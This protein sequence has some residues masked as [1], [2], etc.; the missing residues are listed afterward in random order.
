MWPVP[1]AKVLVDVFLP[2]TEKMGNTGKS[3]AFLTSL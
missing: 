3:Q 2:V 1:Y